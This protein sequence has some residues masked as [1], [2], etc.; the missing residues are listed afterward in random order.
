LGVTIQIGSGL[1]KFVFSQ[2]VI[3]PG[4]RPESGW[5]LE[6]DGDGHEENGVVGNG[7]GNGFGF[8]LGGGYA[9]QGDEGTAAAG[10]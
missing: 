6:S 2:I 5:F 3:C 7:A 10:V 4:G 8:G 1:T 9:G